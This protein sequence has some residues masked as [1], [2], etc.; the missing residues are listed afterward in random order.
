M[1]V[2][3]LIGT[4]F[5]AQDVG[6]QGEVADTAVDAGEGI[7]DKITNK[8][9]VEDGLT[10]LGTL[11]APSTWAGKDT[12][13]S[14][15]LKIAWADRDKTQFSA[16]TDSA[17]TGKAGWQDETHNM[18]AYNA[19]TVKNVYCDAVKKME[20]HV[21]LADELS[22]SRN[23]AGPNGVTGNNEVHMSK[24]ECMNAGKS[25]VDFASDAGAANEGISGTVTLNPYECENSARNLY[26]SDLSDAT[27]TVKIEFRIVS[28]KDESIEFH[29]YQVEA[30]CEFNTLYN[31]N[32]AFGVEQ[33][34]TGIDTEIFQLLDSDFGI[35]MSESS[36]G[37]V[38]G[39]PGF[40]ANENIEAV[41][42]T[43]YDTA[44]ERKWAKLND[45]IGYAPIRCLVEQQPKDT[46]PAVDAVLNTITIFNMDGQGAGQEDRGGHQALEL[47]M[48]ASQ[49]LRIW[50]FKYIA[51]IMAQDDDSG[52]YELQCELQPCYYQPDQGADNNTDLTNK[53]NVCVKVLGLVDVK[54]NEAPLATTTYLQTNGVARVDMGAANHNSYTTVFANA[55]DD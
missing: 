18:R 26:D 52:K 47:A 51:F 13:D 50:Y 11:T 23:P 3:L 20:F 43:N 41:I 7:F 12:L 14:Q 2:F 45:L 46:T 35:V 48:V 6:A 42:Y 15:D 28:S 34:T 19:I 44:S 32:T 29:K 27:V 22:R 53:A 4:A 49:H 33:K 8:K 31:A 21:A 25:Q 55:H 9:D 16:D 39:N 30:T 1:R 17:F 24:F 40:R 37:D 54:H 10:R 36:L 38:H 5:A